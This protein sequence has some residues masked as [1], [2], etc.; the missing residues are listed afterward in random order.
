M[1]NDPVLN[2]DGTP[3]QTTIDFRKE[4]GWYLA[5]VRI[6]KYRSFPMDMLRYDNCQ[7]VTDQDALNAGNISMDRVITMKQR[8][9][10]KFLWTPKRW[11]SFGCEIAVHS[12]RSR[13]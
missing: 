8:A 2:A 5:S 6:P 1:N 7:F 11:Q 10:A 13:T 3:S 12:G 9:T 4:M